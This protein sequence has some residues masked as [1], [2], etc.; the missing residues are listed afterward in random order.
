MAPPPVAGLTLKAQVVPV[1]AARHLDVVRE[2]GF[3]AGLGHVSLLTNV[4][5]WHA[6]H[7]RAG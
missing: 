7:L 4:D 3:V 6:I 2:R 1:R 5:T